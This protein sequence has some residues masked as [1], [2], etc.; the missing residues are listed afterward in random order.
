M[1]SNRSNQLVTLQLQSRLDQ[2]AA[3]WLAQQVE[4]LKQSNQTIWVF[5]MAQVEF[6]DTAGLVSLV[7]ARRAASEVQVQ[8]V[9]CRVSQQ[10][11]M[12]LDLAQLDRVFAIVDRVD[13]L[14][15]PIPHRNLAE[16][17]RQKAA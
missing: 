17:T 1:A 4:Q 14:P 8:L 16:V 2:T 7:A 5:D 12:I 11:Q 6:L 9:L 10:V 3:V 15:L 13:E